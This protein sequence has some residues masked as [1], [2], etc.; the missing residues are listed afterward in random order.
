MQQVLTDAGVSGKGWLA[1]E[2]GAPRVAL[3]SA[4]GGDVYARAYLLKVMLEAQASGMIGVDWFCLSDSATPDTATDP[5]SVMGLY[6]DIANLATTSDAQITSNGVAYKTLGALLGGARFDSAA[7]QALSPSSGQRVL[8][9]ET[10]AGKRAWALWSTVGQDVESVHG[11]YSLPVAGPVALYSWDYA[12]TGAST[13]LSPTNG[14]V[15][16]ETTSVPRIVVEN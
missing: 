3:Q 13:P 5:Y 16:V 12:T 14:H 1:T 2:T 6:L 11:T 15:D 8:A 10:A 7:T 9:F 4:S